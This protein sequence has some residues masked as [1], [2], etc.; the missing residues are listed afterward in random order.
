[1]YKRQALR[2]Q[3]EADNLEVGE[4]KHFGFAQHV[5]G[6]VFHLIILG[7]FLLVV[8]F[9]GF[10][11]DTIHVSNRNGAI[12]IETYKIQGIIETRNGREAKV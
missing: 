7:K 1:M 6:D 2:I 8:S 3:H 4:A 9:I 12:V 11:N 5:G 10:E